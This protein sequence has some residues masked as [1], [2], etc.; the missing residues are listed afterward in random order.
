MGF[1]E[2]SRKAVGEDEANKEHETGWEM[3]VV[4]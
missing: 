1:L 4:I 2:A 3:E